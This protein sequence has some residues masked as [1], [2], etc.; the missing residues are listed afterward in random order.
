MLFSLCIFAYH[1]PAYGESEGLLNSA[2]AYF[3]GTSMYE[4]A[5]QLY[6]ILQAKTTKESESDQK[7]EPRMEQCIT[8]QIKLVSKKLDSLKVNIQNIKDEIIDKIVITDTIMDIP[9]KVSLRSKLQEIYLQMDHVENL[10]HDFIRYITAP[11]KF[12]RD[13]LNEFA[14]HMASRLPNVLETMHS[15]LIQTEFNAGESVLTILS[16]NKQV[17]NIFIFIYFRFFFEII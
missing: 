13:T 15:M 17:K 10:F 11:Q 9:K 3:V 5:D 1:E 14:K 2:I 6:R 16:R 12:S 7:M 4:E 8:D